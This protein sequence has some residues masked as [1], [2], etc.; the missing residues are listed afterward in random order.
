MTSFVLLRSYNLLILVSLL[1][2][3]YYLGSV[4]YKSNPFRSFVP[5]E[6]K[7][8]ATILGWTSLFEDSIESIFGSSLAHCPLVDCVVTNNRT[9]LNKS[10]AVFFHERDFS[11]SDLPHD[12]FPWQYFVIAN[13]EAPPYLGRT[14]SSIVD[15]YFNLTV[16]YRRS[17]DIFI[18][19]FSFDESHDTG[20]QLQ[21]DDALMKMAKHKTKFVAWFVSNCNT[22]S[23]REYYV[24]ELQKHIPVDIYGKCGPLHCPRYSENCS[25]LLKDDYRF[26]LAFENA[27]CLDYTT[28]K[29]LTA[30]SNDVVPIVLSRSVARALL[31]D[32]SFIAVDD[33]ASPKLLAEFLYKL[34]EN[35]S[36][37]IKFFRF[38][39][40]YTATKHELIIKSVCEICQLISNPQRSSIPRYTKN[41]QEWFLRDSNC[42]SVALPNDTSLHSQ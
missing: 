39:R 33:F 34:A 22:P 10:H 11:R 1:V 41:F 2:W 40:K 3:T 6:R 26:Y 28:E 32:N 29:A 23:K 16:T 31:Q 4:V 20:K 42:S 25:Q 37:Y 21:T 38:K 9:M 18:P 19:F 8:V 13:W 27:I 12:R 36:E 35:P 30:L 15:N 17:S 14:T 7:G 5:L 24:K